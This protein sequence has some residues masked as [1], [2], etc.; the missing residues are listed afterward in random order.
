MQPYLT[1]RSH[2]DSLRDRFSPV[3]HTSTFRKTGQITPEEFVAAGD[4]LVYKFPSWSWSPA[5]SAARQVSY[6]PREKQYLVTRGVPCSR[7]LDE[8]FA[9]GEERVVGDGFGKTG[10]DGGEEGE[11]W[12]STGGDATEERGAKV[13][14]VR[15]L[16]ERGEVEREEEM[17]DEEEEIP[18]IDDE[19]EDEEAIIRETGRGK[20]RVLLS[21]LPYYLDVCPP[22]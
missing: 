9:G 14:D 7:R 4:Y 16:G 12:L 5:A 13:G 11:G 2:I 1:L 15:A 21:L 22:F 20:G 6:L 8:N 18:D 17:E 10:G 19:D 3:S